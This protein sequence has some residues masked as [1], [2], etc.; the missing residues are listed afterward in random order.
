MLERNGKWYL[1][2]GA[3]VIRS[4]EKPGN[5]PAASMDDRLNGFADS[6]ERNIL[7]DNLFDSHVRAD[8][9]TSPADLKQHIADVKSKCFNPKEWRRSDGAPYHVGGVSWVDPEL[10]L[11]ILAVMGDCEMYLPDEWCGNIYFKNETKRA[12]LAPV[13]HTEEASA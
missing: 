6:F 7:Q 12:V 11:D 13:R 3:F 8:K 1:I 9:I 5:V 10:L 2:D 4:D